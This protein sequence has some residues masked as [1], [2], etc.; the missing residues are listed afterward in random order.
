[1]V[2]SAVQDHINYL[3][4]EIQK[5]DDRLLAAMTS[6]YKKYW[7]ILQTI[8]GMNAIGAAIFIYYRSGGGHVAI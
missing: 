7:E 3:E 6:S 1:M 8:P 2:L 4:A 5:L